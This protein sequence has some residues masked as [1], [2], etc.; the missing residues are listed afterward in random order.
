M[1]NVCR[2]PERA[3]RDTRILIRVSESP[4]PLFKERVFR[5]GPEMSR[6]RR[7]CASLDSEDRSIES[8]QGK[9]DSLPR[10]FGCLGGCYFA[11]DSSLA[12][13]QVFG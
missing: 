12:L 3:L 11:L 10:G 1:L 8:I 13:L 2:A 5:N 7:F 9:G 4:F 6:A